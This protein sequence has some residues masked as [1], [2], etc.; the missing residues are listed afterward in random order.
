MI[1]SMVFDIFT[2]FDKNDS[3][4]IDKEEAVPIFIELLKS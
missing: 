2:K 4:S 3:G 1:D